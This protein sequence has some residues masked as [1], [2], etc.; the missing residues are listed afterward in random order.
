MRSKLRPGPCL[1]SVL[2]A[3]LFLASGIVRAATTTIKLDLGNLLLTSENGVVADGITDNTARIQALIDLCADNDGGTVRIDTGTVI[4]GMLTLKSNV[5]LDIAGGAV[6]KN[7]GSK[8]HYPFVP[9]DF[10][11]YYPQR[12]AMIYAQNQTNIAVTGDGTIDGDSDSYDRRSSESARVSLIRFDGCTN[13]VV[14]DLRLQS[15]SMWSQHYYR[16]NQ[17]DISGLSVINDMKNDDGLN[18]D[19]CSNVRIT[20]CDITANDDCITLKNTSH[21]LCENIVVSNCILSSTKSAFKFGTES[22][23]GFKNVHASNLTISGGRDA[24]ALFSVD[25]A[26]MENILIENIDITGARCPLVVHLG[27]RLRSIAGDSHPLEIGSIEGIAVRNVNATGAMRA[28]IL[29]GL[30][31]HP[32]RNIHLDNVHIVIQSD[33]A[34]KKE[35]LPDEVVEERPT[36][37]PS[38]DIFGRLNAWGLFVRHARNLTFAN[39]TLRHNSSS[40]A[41][42]A[43]LEDVDNI[44]LPAAI[45][46]DAVYNNAGYAFRTTAVLLEDTGDLQDNLKEPRSLYDDLE[47]RFEACPHYR[48]RISSNYGR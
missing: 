28:I 41:P 46:S 10:L 43:Y 15:A 11:S 37:Y 3:T 25:G 8:D 23:D 35:P 32:V 34:A 39:V 44:N 12:R 2:F 1:S 29:A 40:T 24:L 16:C 17:I 48:E 30:D 6:L 45:E 26:H 38:S 9:V 5:T 4:S 27:A 47:L 21:R 36:S 33:S 19:G 31:G 13:A 22:Y 20:D 14:R 42:M 18:I 7:T